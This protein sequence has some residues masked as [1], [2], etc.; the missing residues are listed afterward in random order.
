MAD[1]EPTERRELTGR[2]A[3]VTGGAMGIGRAIAKELGGAGATIAIAD[4][5]G[6]ETAASEL[7]DM[8]IDA[9]GLEVDVTS[10]EATADMARA[11]VERLGGIDILVNN[12]GVFANLKPRPFEEIDVAEWRLVMDVNV[13]GSFLATR[14]VVPAMR[15]AGGGRIINLGSTSQFRGTANLLHYVSS[16]GAIGGFTRGLAT[17]LGRAGILVN[18]V[19]PGF[20]VSD[21]VTNNPEAMDAMRKVAASRR[22]VS[23]EMVPND[24]VGAIR[25]LAGPYSAFITG[26]T[27]VVDGGAIFH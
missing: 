14:A 1:N 8:G 23:R 26:Q 5:A 6:A 17:E 9:I 25:F 16:K 22:V 21:G 2:A 3:I 27:L 15:E 13:L 12:A 19:A 10:E 24:I 7:A 11:V 20:T 18:C 4:R